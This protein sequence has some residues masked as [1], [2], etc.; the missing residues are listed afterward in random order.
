MLLHATVG[1]LA[2]L[3]LK[4]AVR[5]RL[6]WYLYMY[7]G[8]GLSLIMC[9]IYT[10][11]MNDYMGLQMLNTHFCFFCEI[12]LKRDMEKNIHLW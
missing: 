11:K 9:Y 4:S 6:G 10:V 2:A 1:S 12:Y 8:V 3:D 7:V 5:C